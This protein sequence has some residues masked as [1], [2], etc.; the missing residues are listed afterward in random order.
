MPAPSWLG[1]HGMILVFD[2][3]VR[4][5][6]PSGVLERT[7]DKPKPIRLLLR[8]MLPAP[9]TALH[10]SFSL[11]DRA[12]FRRSLRALL[13]CPRLLCGAEMA[14]HV[15]PRLGSLCCTR[16]CLVGHPRAP[17]PRH[18]L[19]Y[20]GRSPIPL[21]NAQVPE[22]ATH[23][24]GRRADA[25]TKVSPRRRTRSETSSPFLPG[26]WRDDVQTSFPE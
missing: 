12:S 2:R 19:S 23:A 25:Q 16:T 26:L 11:R 6:V 24:M 22:E 17:A 14:S 20:R 15:K 7:G 13:L 21:P 5:F 9:E 1:M 3:P 8:L 18:L 10:P 4:R